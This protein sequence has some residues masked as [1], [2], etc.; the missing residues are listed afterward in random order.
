MWNLKTLISHN[1]RV[2]VVRGWGE[3]RN[4]LKGKYVF[5]QKEKALELIVYSCLET[6]NKLG[7]TQ[8]KTS[9]ARQHFVNK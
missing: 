6:K 2:E 9:S 8:R 5:T 3:G 1:Y 7:V 4:A